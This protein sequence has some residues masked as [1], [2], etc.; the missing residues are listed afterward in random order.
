MRVS[1]AKRVEEV[2]KDL[3]DLNRALKKTIAELKMSK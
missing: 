2:K 1:D 3:I